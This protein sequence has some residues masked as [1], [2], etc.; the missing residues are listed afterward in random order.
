MELDR[1]CWA[2]ICSCV[3]KLHWGM[4]HKGSCSIVLVD[5][6]KTP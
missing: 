3:T 6:V 5:L 4:G 1:P 2:F